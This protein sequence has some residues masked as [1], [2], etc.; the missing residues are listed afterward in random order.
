MPR[1]WRHAA[2]A[3]HV[4]YRYRAHPGTRGK[5]NRRNAIV[6]QE[7]ERQAR[8][9]SSQED[10]AIVADGTRNVGR[11]LGDTPLTTEDAWFPGTTAP[12]MTPV[13]ARSTR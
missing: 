2:F 3:R 5:G 7:A 12:P 11:P 10:P 1:G 6:T 9:P 13:S 8:V 4:R